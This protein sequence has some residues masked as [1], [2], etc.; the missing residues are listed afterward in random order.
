MIIQFRPKR[1]YVTDIAI[2]RVETGFSNTLLEGGG[3]IPRKREVY[4]LVADHLDPTDD[5]EIQ[6][7]YQGW[8]LFTDYEKAKAAL[9]AAGDP[10]SN[11]DGWFQ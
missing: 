2:T 9:A 4:Y 5:P 1:R 6:E 11:P 10:I 8:D 3:F 7:R